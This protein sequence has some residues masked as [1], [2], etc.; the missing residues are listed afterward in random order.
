MQQARGRHQN[1]AAATLRQMARDSYER[2][3]LLDLVNM[4]RKSDP[5]FKGVSEERIFELAYGDRQTAQAAYR[6]LV[7]EDSKLYD[8]RSV[9]AFCLARIKKIKKI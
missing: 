4:V 8:N 3:P 6:A 2:K 7:D 5:V 9:R 1:L